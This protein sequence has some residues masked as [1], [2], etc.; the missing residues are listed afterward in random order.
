MR[1]TFLQLLFILVATATMK[2]Q[3]GINYQ[4][5]VRNSDGEILK[6]QNVELKFSVLKGSTSGTEVYAETHSLTTNNFGNVV[7]IIGQGTATTGTFTS[8]EWGNDKHFLNVKVDGT[9]M[10][11]TQFMSVPY[12]INAE[13]ANQTKMIN[14]TKVKVN[15]NED[16]RI[17]LGNS[18]P[19]DVLA[20]G[21]SA[22]KSRLAGA[23]DGG[24]LVKLMVD[25]L[26]DNLGGE[27]PEALLN[28]ETGSHSHADASL[29]AG[30]KNDNY[31]FS[32]GVNGNL[33]AEERIKTDGNIVLDGEVNRPN[34]TGTANLL[35]IA[36][37]LVNSSG[38]LLTGTGN[39]SVVRSSTGTY[40]ISI[41]GESGSY[42][43]YIISTTKIINK[44]TTRVYGNSVSPGTVR[45]FSYNTTFTLANSGFYFVIYKP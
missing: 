44:G 28:L 16:G 34:T 9:D 5:V 2:A 37:G 21:L 6:N 27:Y 35:P 45:I 29:I 26:D 42:S 39:V 11:T 43:N 38:T 33:Y 23:Q 24:R 1:K 3:T 25:T 13:S 40:D 4:A 14:E 15:A 19:S 36:Y 18:D 20:E 12:A 8:I 22:Y 32:V 30:L 41:A 17:I 31:V 7:A 10:G